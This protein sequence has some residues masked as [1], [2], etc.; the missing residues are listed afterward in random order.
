MVICAYC[1]YKA[2]DNYGVYAVE[3]LNLNQLEAASLITYASYTRPI[4]AIAAGFWADRWKPSGLIALSFAC[5]MAAF[6]TLS[7]TNSTALLSTVVMANLLVTFIAVYA[8]RGIY[9]SLIE[10]TGVDQRVTGT[11][12]GLISMLGFTPDIFFS[13]ITGRILDANPGSL[14][15]QHYFLLMAIISAIGM[16][17]TLALNR[18]LRIRA[19]TLK[20]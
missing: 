14:G 8:L 19:S 4:A 13:S 3:V 20:G 1:G 16:L 18:Q 15:F 17:C 6:L 9:F 12:V 10:E 5:A 7:Q 2:L 11:A